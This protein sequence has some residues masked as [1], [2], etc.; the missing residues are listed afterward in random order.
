MS[1]LTTLKH[2]ISMLETNGYDLFN[3]KNPLTLDFD[4]F[5]SIY[6][7]V[8]SG[9]LSNYYLLGVQKVVIKLNRLYQ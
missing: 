4:L 2:K 5:V 6:L 9:Y 1:G 8:L 3:C 7:S